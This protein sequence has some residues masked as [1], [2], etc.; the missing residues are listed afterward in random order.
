MKI[1]PFLIVLLIATSCIGQDEKALVG[2]VWEY[3]FSSDQNDYIKF[4]SENKFESYSAESGRTQLG[5]YFISND[6]LNLVVTHEIPNDRRSVG[7]HTRAIISEGSLRYISFDRIKRDKWESSDF[8][9]DP[10]YVLKK[11]E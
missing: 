2:T 6:T 5:V 4:S 9:F 1:L 10:E 8:M 11:K 7:K 3:S